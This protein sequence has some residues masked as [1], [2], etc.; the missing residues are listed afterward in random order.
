MRTF[1]AAATTSWG[2]LMALAPLLQ[3]RIMIR[4]RS[5]AEVSTGWIAILLVGFILWLAYGL[6][7]D[8]WPLIISNSVAFT[9]TAVA[10]AV[11]LFYR[12]RK[13]AAAITRQADRE[14]N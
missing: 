7:T 12:P 3:V 5:S 4:R 8:D 13:E 1:L 14:A 2:L 6:V 11:I 10:L 9:V